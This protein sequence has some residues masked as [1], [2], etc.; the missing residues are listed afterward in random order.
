M[1]D[2]EHP[3]G[4]L[5]GSGLSARWE[6]HGPTCL[7]CLIGLGSGWKCVGGGRW[8]VNTLALGTTEQHR[9]GRMSRQDQP[10]MLA[11]SP[12]VERLRGGVRWRVMKVGVCFRE[13]HVHMILYWRE[14]C[15]LL[16]S[17]CSSLLLKTLNLCYNCWPDWWGHLDYPEDKSCF[18]LTPLTF[19][20]SL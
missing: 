14:I 18:W 16:W 5:D 3:W 13:L 8:E 7:G 2:R 17:L 4:R 10:G 9:I 12:E 11:R 1:A 20:L 6:G 15:F 19:I